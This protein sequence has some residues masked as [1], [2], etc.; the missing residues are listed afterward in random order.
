MARHIA[1]RIKISTEIL[2]F[3]KVQAGTFEQKK[4]SKIYFAHLS[5]GKNVVSFPLYKSARRCK[6]LSRGKDH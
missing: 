6:Q 2:N 5:A 4:V 3:D 1:L